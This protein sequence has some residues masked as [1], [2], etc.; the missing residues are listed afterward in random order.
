MNST[1]LGIIS[2]THG[3]L[4]PEAVDRLRGV[5]HIIHA[6]D[7]GAPDILNRLVD[8]APVT[9]V[10]GNTD[11]GHWAQELPI[12]NVVELDSVSFYIIH[13]LQDLDIDPVAAG[14]SAVISGHSH[15]PAKKQDNGVLYLNPGSIGPR[16]FH[17]PV[18]MV[19]LDIVDGCL[20]PEF[21]EIDV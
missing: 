5:N 11:G 21:I 12:T 10:R 7:V 15:A 13:I 3:L 19:R 17:L 20:E 16:R 8:I 14:F 1:T 9:A 6:G 2:D 4:R 18:S